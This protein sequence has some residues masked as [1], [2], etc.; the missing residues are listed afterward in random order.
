MV[1][2]VP[3]VS[4]AQLAIDSLGNVRM[5]ESDSNSRVSFYNSD[6][7]STLFIKSNGKALNINTNA[8][9]NGLIHP[10]RVFILCP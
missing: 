4:L 2:L 10:P 3:S 1:F 6:S 7:T 5:G 9:L 8:N